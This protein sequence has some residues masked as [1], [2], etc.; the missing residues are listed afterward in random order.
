MS[1]AECEHGSDPYCC[2]PCQGYRSTKVERAT[3]DITCRRC[4]REIDEGD[5]YRRV[6][7]VPVCYPEC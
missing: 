3:K 7:G 6:E 4:S 2:L 1:Y 5:I